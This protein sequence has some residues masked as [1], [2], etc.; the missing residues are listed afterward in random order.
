MM[1]ISMLESSLGPPGLLFDLLSRCG[2]LLIFYWKTPMQ[3]IGI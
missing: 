1:P 2:I 3:I